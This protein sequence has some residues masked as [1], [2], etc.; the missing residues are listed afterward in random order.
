M[1]FFLSIT[2]ENA[3]FGDEDITTHSAAPEIAR[4]LRKAAEQIEG[5]IPYDYFQTIRDVNGNDVGAY[6][7]K[8][9]SYFEKG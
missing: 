9:K 1:K 7:F 8:P 3:A 5:G 6:A 4:I 2:C